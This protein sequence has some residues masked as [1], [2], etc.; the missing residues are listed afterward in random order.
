MAQNTSLSYARIRLCFA[1]TDPIVMQSAQRC[2]SIRTRSLRPQS[3]VASTG[4][5]Q[6]AP[7][8]T[9]LMQVRMTCASWKLTRQ[10]DFK[11]WPAVIWPDR[12]RATDTSKQWSFQPQF[13]RLIHFNYTQEIIINVFA[14]KQL[15]PTYAK[16]HTFVIITAYIIITCYQTHL[17]RTLYFATGLGTETKLT[18]F[19]STINTRQNTIHPHDLMFF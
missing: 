19:R 3:I 9:R 13:L 15:H 12:S 16:A 10:T 4:H 8:T 18:T 1:L 6:T 5:T 11:H 14:S 7:S 2:Y 17:T